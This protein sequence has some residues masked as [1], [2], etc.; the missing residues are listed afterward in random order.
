MTEQDIARHLAHEQ[1]IL[2][3]INQN[4]ST[5]SPDVIVDELVASREQTK[6]RIAD[7]AL[8]STM[9]PLYPPEHHFGLDIPPIGEPLDAPHAPSFTALDL[10]DHPRLF[11]Y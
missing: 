3:D 10:D 4:L 8:M 6:Q 1:Q 2:T 7:L 11:N 5:A 9:T